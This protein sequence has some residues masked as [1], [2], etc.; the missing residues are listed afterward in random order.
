MLLPNIISRSNFDLTGKGS[1]YLHFFQKII[2]QEEMFYYITKDVFLLP[3]C[4]SNR[5]TIWILFNSVLWD[6]V[7]SKKTK[8]ASILLVLCFGLARS[9]KCRDEHDSPS[10]SDSTTLNLSVKYNVPLFKCG[11]NLRLAT[12]NVNNDSTR[13]PITILCLWNE[14]GLRS[15]SSPITSRNMVFSLNMPTVGFNDTEN[16]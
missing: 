15:W 16:K 13:V 5:N 4:H 7:V 10:S 1:F 9:K 12:Q 3:T 2:F 6:V 11:L 8:R 14:T